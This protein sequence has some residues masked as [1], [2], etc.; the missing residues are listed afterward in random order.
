MSLVPTVQQ[1]RVEEVTELKKEFTDENGMCTD[2]QS[3]T[4]VSTSQA[5][6]D[7]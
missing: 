6:D 2:H 1:N 4:P 7:S 3:L 5:D